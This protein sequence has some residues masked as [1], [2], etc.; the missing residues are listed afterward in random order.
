[1]KLRF[2]GENPPLKYLEQFP[3]WS[4][5]YDE[6]DEDDQDETTLKPHEQQ[7]FIDDDVSFTAADVTTADE[8]K[9]IALLEVIAGVPSAFF[10]YGDEPLYVRNSDYPNKQWESIPE[11]W[12]IGLPENKRMK[13]VLFDDPNVFPLQLKS[14]LPKENG[15]HIHFQI[16][17]NRFSTMLG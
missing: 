12:Q 5:A 7:Q 16:E 13:E 4:N 3:N 17:M 2:T 1:M 11:T 15:K 9:H 10:M 14:R 8:T 6:E